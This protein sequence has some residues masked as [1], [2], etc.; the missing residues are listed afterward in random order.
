MAT[1]GK[2][3]SEQPTASPSDI[4][5]SDVLLFNDGSV[6]KIVTIADFFAGTGGVPAVFASVSGRDV[7]ADGSKLDGIEPQATADQTGAEIKAAYEGEADT[8]AFTDAEQSKLSGIEPGA[9]ADQ[10]GAEIKA[11][12]EGEADTN[13]F[14]DA[15]KSKLS[16]IEDGAE[17]NEVTAVNSQTG[18][19]V[20]DADDIDDSSTAHKFATAGQLSKLD[21]IEQGATADQTGAEIKA[22]YEAEADTNA[23]TDA[24]Q[25]KLSAIE[26]GATAD[27]TA[28]E[29]K[30]A[31][32]SEPDT[33][34]FT[35]A[36]QSKL[37]GIE[38][39]ADV[40]D[41]G[42]VEAAGALMDSELT[43]ESA[44]KAIDQGLS[45]TDSPSF[46]GLTSDLTGNVTGNVTGDVTGDVTGTV[47]DVSNHST[48]DISEGASNLY[49]LDHRVVATQPALYQR[50]RLW[51]LD[52]SDN[53]TLVSPS[54]LA[55]R[56]GAQGYLLTAEVSLDLSQASSWDTTSPTDYT[57]A[58]NRAGKDFYLYAVEPSSG[59]T[60]DFVLS[61]NSTIPS[62]YTASDARKIGGFHCLCV[63]VGTISDH[64]LSDF[65]AGDILPQSIWDLHHRSSGTQDGTVYDPHSRLWVDIYLASWS[66]SRMESID[67]GT[68]A[69]GASSPHFHWYNF[70]ELFGYEGKRL[71]RQDE[72]IRF[73]R[74]SNQETNISGSSDPGTT[75]G[76]TDTAG[77]RMISDI[78]VE[79]ACGVMWQWGLENS[80]DKAWSGFN[81]ADTSGDGG[82]YDGQNSIA[83]GEGFDQPNRP[84]FGGSWNN[85]AE[86]GSRCAAWNESPLSLVASVGARGV[87]LPVDNESGD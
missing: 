59:N 81:P 85:G 49:F 15:E 30:S 63:A 55:L 22:A 8:N 76:H 27:Q 6:T 54:Q 70:V 57:V 34:A 36:E 44:V 4:D 11:A 87:A 65:A 2:K 32:E 69:D 67:G 61:A 17:V 3:I 1:N 40:T 18:A 77:R 9:T 43:D 51:K 38:S 31:Y 16:G 5:G 23:F 62:G 58:S 33:N 42:N 73:T 29:I 48:D 20:L 72:F 25:S 56:I 64:E 14:T 13:A 78:G 68:I 79:D 35:D 75:T 19:V 84:R 45:T 86:C 83:R 41:A 52:S 24:E 28:A 10:T 80:A 7:S 47:S 37:S 21:G 71:P 12:Y 60:P 50:D 46:A 39:Q 74:G 26:Q 66:G 82:T 53:A